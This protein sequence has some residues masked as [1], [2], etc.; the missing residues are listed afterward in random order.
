MTIWPPEVDQGLD[1]ETKITKDKFD[2]GTETIFASSQLPI[3]Y[4]LLLFIYLTEIS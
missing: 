2:Y 1:E 3:C 4:L